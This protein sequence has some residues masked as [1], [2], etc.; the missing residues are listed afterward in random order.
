MLE[1]AARIQMLVEATPD[2]G[3]DFTADDIA[4]LRDRLPKPDQFVVNFDYLV[5][6]LAPSRI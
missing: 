3:S 4:A 6:R 2:G 1:T 5:R